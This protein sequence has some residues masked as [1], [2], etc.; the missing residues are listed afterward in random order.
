M[1]TRVSEGI[2]TGGSAAYD[3]QKTFFG[4]SALG[5]IAAVS[6]PLVLSI[7]TFQSVA[8]K[9]SVNNYTIVWLIFGASYLIGIVS[10]ALIIESGIQKTNPSQLMYLLLF[11]VMACF[12]ISVGSG[13][14]AV[15][16]MDAVSSVS[17]SV[18][19]K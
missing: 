14:V 17:K 8:N 13:G 12:A 3:W 1:Q 11:I 5:P 9:D 2:R 6:L 16:S 19:S 18:Q 4:E 10:Y 7:C 15:L